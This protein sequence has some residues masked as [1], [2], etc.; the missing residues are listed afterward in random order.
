MT[1]LKE[2]AP[3]PDDITAIAGSNFALTTPVAEQ[4]GQRAGAVGYGPAGLPVENEDQQSLVTTLT[5]PETVT[6][7]AEAEE[8]KPAPKTDV[9]K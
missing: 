2:G 1:D 8:E 3:A 5:S 6:E 9:K 7:V 4:N